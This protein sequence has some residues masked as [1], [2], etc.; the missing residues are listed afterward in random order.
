F[1]SDTSSP[2]LIATD[3]YQRNRIATDR[4]RSRDD[5]T[6]FCVLGP[7]HLMTLHGKPEQRPLFRS[8]R[9]YGVHASGAVRREKTSKKRRAREHESCS[10]E[11]Q[12][13]A[14]TYVIQDFGQ[15]ASCGQ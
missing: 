1:S 15:N 14:R 2:M 6:V 5:A 7:E 13:I 8:K 4:S 10:N 12:W 3:V 11:R 9:R